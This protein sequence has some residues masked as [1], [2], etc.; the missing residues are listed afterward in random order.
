MPVGRANCQSGCWG[1]A[2]IAVAVRTTCHCNVF[3][4][5]QHHHCSLSRHRGNMQAHTTDLGRLWLLHVPCA[6]VATWAV[7][8]SSVPAFLGWAGGTSTHVLYTVSGM[9]ALVQ[10]P[11][12]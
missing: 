5:G 1:T 2:F 8:I 9:G 12:L 3:C 10:I 11:P 7:T 4:N 6:A